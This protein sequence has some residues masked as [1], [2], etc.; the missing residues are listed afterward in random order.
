MNEVEVDAR[1]LD[2]KLAGEIVRRAIIISG[3][4]PV[5]VTVDSGEPEEAVRRAAASMKRNVVV[6]GSGQG[7]LVLELVR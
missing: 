3:G 7:F 5:T 4:C 6:K 2:R 1:G